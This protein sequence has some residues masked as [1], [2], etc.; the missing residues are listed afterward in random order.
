VAQTRARVSELQASLN[1]AELPARPD[2]R[3][4][5]QAQA[6]AASAALRQSEWRRE[7]KQQARRSMPRWPTP[8]PP[9]RVRG[10]GPAGAVAAAAGG[11]QGALLRA[12]AEVGR[13]KTGERCS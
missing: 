4:A 1:T 8:F 3:A 2:E 5:A 11:H 13:I 6:Q 10:R 12:R 9:R 7:Q